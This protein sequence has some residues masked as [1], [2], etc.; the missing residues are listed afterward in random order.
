MTQV[1]LSW[2]EIREKGKKIA[3][4]FTVKMEVSK[5]REMNTSKSRKTAAQPIPL[6]YLD[7]SV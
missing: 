6:L 7:P 1:A 4:N 5:V 3:L 2:N